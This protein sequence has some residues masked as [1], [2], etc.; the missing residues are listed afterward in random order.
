MGGCP[1]CVN[2]KGEEKCKDILKDLNINPLC[3]FSFDDHRKYKYDFCFSYNNINFILEYDGK[4]HFKRSKLFHETEEEFEMSRNRD[5]FKTNLALSRGFR[6]IR[7]DY[8]QIKIL[9][10]HITNAIEA[11][12]NL[13]LSGKEMYSWL[14]IE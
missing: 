7:I 1:T 5:I 8:T 13:Y 11:T 6:I 14:I 4:Q 12:T 10:E 3:Q 9:K 2:S